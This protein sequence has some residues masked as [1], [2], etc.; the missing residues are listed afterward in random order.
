MINKIIVVSALIVAMQGTA[1]GNKVPNQPRKEGGSS[2]CPPTSSNFLQN[3]LPWNFPQ[4][5]VSKVDASGCGR[6]ENGI[7]KCD[8]P[9]DPRILRKK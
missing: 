9:R 1:F 5:R 6:M 4:R 7:L 2:S 3:L 8:N